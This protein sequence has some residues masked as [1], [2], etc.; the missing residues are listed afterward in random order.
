MNQ[1]VF[2]HA[3]ALIDPTLAHMVMARAARR[4]DLHHEIRTAPHPATIGLRPI[5]IHQHVRLNN[6]VDVRVVLV[7]V[8]NPH[9]H[10]GD[11]R[12]AGFAFERVG[13]LPVDLAD[14]ILM[15]AL[16]SV[17][18]QGAGLGRMGRRSMSGAD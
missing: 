5:A 16:A 17:E 14:H 9:I 15:I 7:G 3:D 11:V 1:P 18:H 4:E 6:G 13:Q 10:R 8:G 2:A 12:A